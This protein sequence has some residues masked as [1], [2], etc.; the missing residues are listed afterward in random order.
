MQPEFL[1]ELAKSCKKLGIH[2]T[3]DTSGHASLS[4][5]KMVIPYIDLF[6]FDIKLL[7]DRIHKKFTGVSH[8]QILR[9]LDFISAKKKK[10]IIRYP[11]IPG[12]NNS[13]EQL[14]QLKK[15]IVDRYN[16]IHLL[17][18]HKIAAHKYKKLSIENKLPDIN[19][20]SKEYLETLKDDFKESGFNVKIGG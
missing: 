10:I 12:I 3:L 19:P 6:L 16:E 20:I 4:A 2:T 1:K 7:D 5:L 18:Y 15:F 13:P 8:K 14:I 17:P 9:I 11:I